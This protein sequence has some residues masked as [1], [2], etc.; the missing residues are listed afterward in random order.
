MVSNAAV[1]VVSDA[2]VMT[3]KTADV[4]IVAQPESIAVAQNAT[5]T[6]TVEAEGDNLK[7]RWYRSNDLGQTWTETWLTGY[8]TNELSFVATAA[9]AG[10]VYKCVI[11]S[12]VTTVET[13][14]ASVVF[15]G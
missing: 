10:Y 9:R 7:Y 3:I 6:F 2:A 1:E 4:V 11:T 14:P 13:G 5:V 15:V 8:N 12:G